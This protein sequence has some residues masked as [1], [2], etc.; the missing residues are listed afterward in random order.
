MRIAFMGSAEF[1]LPALEALVEAGHSIAC[2]YCQSARPAGRG[3]KPR[4]TIIEKRASELGLEVRSPTSL[5]GR[6]DEFARLE[7][8]AGVVA[9]YGN[10]IPQSIL[11]IP[12]G[13]FLNIHPSLLPRWRG[14]APVQRAI[15]EGDRM[16]GVCIM[17][18]VEKLDAGPVL[19][20]RTMPILDDD[21]STGL[22]RKLSELGATMIVDALGE[23]GVLT[24][25][26]QLA[27]GVRYARKIEKSETRV[28]WSKPAV[29]VDRKI[30]G[31][32]A[33]PGAWCEIKG[34]RV[35]LLRSKVVEAEGKP[36][37][38]LDDRFTIACGAGA[39]RVTE[40]QRAGKSK[41]ASDAYLRGSPIKTGSFFS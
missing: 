25:S 34:E 8:D 2:A 35:K 30:R 37:Q 17:K 14:A 39:V 9:A 31:L 3:K 28:D 21:T 16:T 10:L 18:V 12:S 24:E 20:Q 7:L 15:M 4:A 32:S 29:E 41:L 36:G 19:T 38:V 33:V 22:G 26:P 5:A 40:V 23:L 6:Q 1:A 27:D 11:E 13:G